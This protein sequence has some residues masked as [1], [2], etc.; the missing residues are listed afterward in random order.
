MFDDGQGHLALLNVAQNTLTAAAA[1]PQ[2]GDTTSVNADGN[3][4]AA[5]MGVYDGNLAPMVSLGGQDFFYTDGSVNV[6]PTFSAPVAFNASGSLLFVPSSQGQGEI[7]VFDVHHGNVVLRIAVAG[8]DTYPYPFALD[9]TGT[10]LFVAELENLYVIQ[11]AEA[12]LS[13]ASVNPA[14]AAPGTS[15]TI[16][17]SGF[18]SGTTVQFGTT[19]AS[20]EF[21]DAMTLTVT[22]P[23]AASGP[24]QVTVTNPDGSSYSLD[25]AFTV[26]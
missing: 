3:E 16:R 15:V 25:D 19:A 2:Q 13:I 18:E 7:Y 22:A 14:S 11:L 4:F 23:S 6:Q 12:P 21:V 8:S 24:T 10:E 20:A 9:T 26:N 1:L 17:G 5:T